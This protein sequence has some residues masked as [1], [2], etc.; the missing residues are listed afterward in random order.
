M[1]DFQDKANYFEFYNL[2]GYELNCKI[3]LRALLRA[4][5]LATFVAS[6]EKFLNSSK[7]P[8]YPSRPMRVIA[9]NRD[10]FSDHGDIMSSSVRLDYESVRARTS[11]GHF[12]GR[13]SV[14]S[15]V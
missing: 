3:K 4:L 15:L 6:D 8:R 5:R 14:A 1:C 9:I 10:N 7:P 2:P 11:S 13:K 12:F